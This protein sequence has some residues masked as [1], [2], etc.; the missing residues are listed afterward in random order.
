MFGDPEDVHRL[1]STTRLR[2]AASH[3]AL[4]ELEQRVCDT[5]NTV[6]TTKA[7]IVR[8]DELIHWLDRVYPNTL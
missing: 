2:P 3:A 8:S 4:R 1:V 5:L 7:V 6:R